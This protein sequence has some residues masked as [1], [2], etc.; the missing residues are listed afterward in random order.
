MGLDGRIFSGDRKMSRRGTSIWFRRAA[1]AGIFLGVAVLG[2]GHA[3]AGAN[4]A[5]MLSE[6]RVDIYASRNED[7]VWMFHDQPLA[8]TL[9]RVELG[10]QAANLF[11]V[12]EDRR[13]HLGA[14]LRQALVDKFVRSDVFTLHHLDSHPSCLGGD[15]FGQAE[16]YG[17]CIYDA[18]TV[19]VVVG[20]F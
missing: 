19:P 10:P 3:S 15:D 5:T 18:V 7:A 11:F 17:R 12:F 13:L 1:A 2:F 6:M 8:S 9:V 16:W 14:P 20:D 4:E